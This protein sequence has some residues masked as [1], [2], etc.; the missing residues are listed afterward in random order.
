[1]LRWGMAKK[2]LGTT[3]I[4]SLKSTD[5]GSIGGMSR[6]FQTGLDTPSLLRN[7][8]PFCVAKQ[9]DR[10]ADKITCILC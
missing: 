3:A 10:V 4:Q 9:Y 8:I 5:Y 6:E 2:R 1:M 7:N